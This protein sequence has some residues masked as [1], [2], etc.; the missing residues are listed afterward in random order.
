MQNSTQMLLYLIHLIKLFA[1]KKY[2][3]QTA[4]VISL[5]VTIITLLPNRIAAQKGWQQLFNGKDFTGW[6]KLG[7]TA[8]YTIDNGVLVGTTVLGSG[9]TFLT[10]EKEYGDFIL[11]LDVMI[12][13]TSNNSGIQTRS[14]F[15]TKKGRVYGRQIE[16]DPTTR[17]WTGGVYDEARREWLYPMDLNATAKTAFKNGAFNHMRIECIGNETK[18]WINNIATSYV[19]DTL[20]ATGFIGLQVHAIGSAAHANKRVFFKNIKIQTTGFK[21]ANFDKNVYVVNNIPNN[22]TRYE[23]KDGWQ[24]LFDGNTTT[25]WKS[26]KGEDFPAKGWQVND[27]VLQ[28]LSSEGKEST[29]GG[30]IVSEKQY[31]AFDL[32]FNFKLT[33]GANSG[34]KYFVTLAEKSSGSAIG[35]EYQILDDSLH[36]DAKLGR[37]GNRTLASL[38]DLMTANKQKRFLRKIGEWNI[39]RVV[40]YPDNRVEHYLNGV[41]VLSYTRGSEE[42]RNLVA[43]SKYHVWPNFGEAKQGH[44]LLQDHG[45]AVSFKSIK[46]KAL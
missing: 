28:V 20:D 35:L 25:G 42:F 18:T 22:L 31:G 38:Y 46:I 11:E 30:D 8:N 13:D 29:N 33:A 36:P 5:F 2:A 4:F 39:G 44:I 14:H 16:I 12:E 32:S 21:P 37:S 3:S 45:N 41:K 10:T 1:M 40:V 27:G 15:D 34:V 19:V 24:L 17:A 9:N 23:Q 43:I 6:K 7:G 26:A